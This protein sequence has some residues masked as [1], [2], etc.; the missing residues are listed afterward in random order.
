M[1]FVKAPQKPH[2]PAESALLSFVLERALNNKP[3]TT[4]IIT[5]ETIQTTMAKRLPLSFPNT[6]TKGENTNDVALG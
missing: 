2:T 4:P 5:L 3:A 1:V 6:G